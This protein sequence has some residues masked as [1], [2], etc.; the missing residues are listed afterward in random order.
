MYA[1]C[2]DSKSSLTS[3][4]LISTRTPDGRSTYATGI[5]NLLHATPSSISGT[6]PE[7]GTA[8]VESP[9]VHEIEPG[10][11]SPHVLE[12]AFPL[13]HDGGHNP[14]AVFIDEFVREKCVVQLTHPVRR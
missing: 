9:Y 5:L 14:Q 11:R 6:I 12:R 1:W 8:T 13:I 3:F 2:K 4:F 10:Q 7:D